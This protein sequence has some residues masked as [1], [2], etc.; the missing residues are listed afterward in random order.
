LRK[1]V[2][3][4]RKCGFVAIVLCNGIAV[5]AQD[6]K[7]IQ[8]STRIKKKDSVYKEEDLMDIAHKVFKT[9]TVPEADSEK[10]KPGQ[11][12]LA[13]FPAAG[14]ALQSG[15]VAI[16]AANVSFYTDRAPTNLSSVTISPQYSLMQQFV[17][18]VISNIWTSNNKWNFLGDWR[19][20]KYPSYTYGLG[21]RSL[22]SNVDSID[23]SYFKFY[24][25][26]L[27]EI[28]P[29]LYGGIGYNLDYHWNIKDY[30]TSTDFIDYDQGQTRTVSSGLVANIKYDNRV[31]VNNPKSAFYGSVI[32]R[33]NSTLLGSD[34]NWQYVQVEMRKYFKL[35]QRG[36]NV[37][38]FWS[39][40]E[41]TFG[42]KPPYLDLP[43][44]GWDTYNNTGR[45]YIQG[46]FRGNSMVYLESEF[47]FDITRN[48][49]FGG[50]L[51]ANAE[52]VST[53]TGDDFDIISPG[54]GFG[55]RIKLNRFSNTNLAVDYG[56]GT[57]GSRGFF[58]N[59][60][61]VF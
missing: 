54:Y 61:E 33:Y 29:H 8:D 16:V 57:G 31:N 59:I 1:T 17:L 10:T 38:A 37:L 2:S 13:I 6:S 24:Q 12:L 44:T 55:I 48:G 27:H 25:E 18:P 46:R 30:N 53:E 56:F 34:E 41:F 20:Y 15:A 3:K 60:G 58:F 22:L 52:S 49:L 42:G 32:Y 14:Y 51:F 11:I 21:S 28:V 47:R 7:T 36:T 9:K 4:I 19:F 43:S 39:W 45:G 5:S 23:Y 40:N 35:N 26:V 50:V